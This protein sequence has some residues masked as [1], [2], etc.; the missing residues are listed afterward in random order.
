MRRPLARGAAERRL[1]RDAD[2]PSRRSRWSSAA[3]LADPDETVRQAAIHSGEPLAR[4][5]GRV[6]CWLGCSTGHPLQNRRAA[7]EAL[8]R[9]GDKSAVPALL[10]A[11][12]E[13]RPDRVLEHSLT[14]ALIE[15][16]DPKG[17][18]A[19]LASDQPA[20]PPRGPGRA[21]PDGRGGLGPATGRRAA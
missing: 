8:G 17:T 16:A 7:A 11:V 13:L 3:A 4:P 10:K 5:G 21:R 1:G 12:G 15:I 19:G 2:R 9:I 20:G 6:R 14:Y 18:A